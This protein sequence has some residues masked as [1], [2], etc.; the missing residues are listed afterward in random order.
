M[1]QIKKFL[2]GTALTSLFICSSAFAQ[3]TE[4]KAHFIKNDGVTISNFEKNGRSNLYFTTNQEAADALSGAVFSLERNGVLFSADPANLSDEAETMLNA[5]SSL[6]LLGGQERVP[7]AIEQYQGY[8]NRFSGD[9]RYATAVSV[10]KELGVSR[11]LLIINGDTY[12]DAISAT[13]IAAKEDRNI[14]M[15]SKDVV[16]QATKE[17]LENF[18]R[19]KDVLFVGG[20]EALS[21]SVKEEIAA[22]TGLSASEIEKRTIAGEDRYQTS[23]HLSSRFGHTGQVMIANGHD[24]VGALQASSLSDRLDA[25]LLLVSNDNV[26]EILDAASTTGSLSEVYAFAD[27][28]N[29]DVSGYV[30][31]TAKSQAIASEEVF[32]LNENQEPIQLTVTTS[33]AE[34]LVEEEAPAPEVEA[35]AP[36][37]EAPVVNPVESFVNAAIQMEGWA[38]SQSL[39]MS[40][41]YAD[42]SSLVLKA[43]INSGLVEDRWSNLTSE[44]I[45]GDGRFYQVSMNDMQRGDVLYQWGHLA[46]YMGDGLIFEASDYGVPAGFRNYRSG[47]SAAFRINGL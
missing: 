39:R 40:D 7:E 6:H 46:I 8:K 41:G 11:N 29:F 37:V 45:W 47:F 4:F 2:I 32:F 24:Y 3:E 23:I 19:G 12:A 16:P 21:T 20:E 5:A 42:C 1:K 18:G 44:S 30:A 33:S 34:E 28:S 31:F 26:E 36:E 17:Y 38:Y 10:A 22:I 43:L 15:V 25:P 14:L 35:P 27:E 9:D 13:P